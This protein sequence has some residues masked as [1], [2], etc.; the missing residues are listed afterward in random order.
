[1][2]TEENESNIIEEKYKDEYITITNKELIINKYTLPFFGKKVIK[3]QKI[4]KIKIISLGEFS[5]KYKFYGLS[6][7]LYWF[8][9]DKKRPLKDK[10]ILIETNDLI[11]PVITP[12]NVD[13]VFNI[14]NEVLS[15]INS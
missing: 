14:L 5:G 4:K 11:K 12:T 8:H 15:S 3:L 7:K 1:M 10:G 2:E 13:H 9:F 6:L